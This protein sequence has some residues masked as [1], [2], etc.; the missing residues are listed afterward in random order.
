MLENIFGQKAGHP[1]L[2]REICTQLELDKK[3]GK[4]LNQIATK[5]NQEMPTMIFVD[6]NILRKGAQL[7]EAADSVELLR[8][9]YYKWFGGSI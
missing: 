3:T 5:I 6:P 1:A 4:I 7:P 2:F 9:L 8:E